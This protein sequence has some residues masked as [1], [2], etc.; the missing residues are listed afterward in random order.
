MSLWQFSVKLITAAAACDCT[1]GFAAS[2]MTWVR[3]GRTL[4]WNWFWRS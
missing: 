2:S 1:R 4:A 3:A